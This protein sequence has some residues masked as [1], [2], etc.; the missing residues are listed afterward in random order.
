MVSKAMERID[1]LLDRFYNF[2]SY[3]KI[4]YMI[5]KLENKIIDLPLSPA[6]YSCFSD[7]LK[8]EDANEILYK[9]GYSLSVII[10]ILNRV[11]TIK[12]RVENECKKQK[13]YF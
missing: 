1:R 8:L 7:C 5:E 11:E 4:C 2:I 10:G 12:E 9:S 3:L 6:R 13:K